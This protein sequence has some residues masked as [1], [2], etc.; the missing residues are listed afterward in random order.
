[1]RLKSFKRG[2]ALI[3]IAGATAASAPLSA[4]AENKTPVAYFGERA[5]DSTEALN[6][7]PADAKDVVVARIRLLTH[8]FWLGGRHCEFCTDDIFGAHLKVTEVLRGRS[9]IGQ[10]LD[11][12]LGQ[13]SDYRPFEFPS[14]PDQ[15]GREYTVVIYLAADGLRRLAAFPVSQAE[16]E[17]WNEERWSHQGFTGKP[18]KASLPTL[19]P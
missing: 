13:R 17:K 1:M 14:T 16:Y 3:A 8:L 2:M 9:E 4:A 7:L 18:G 19:P 11:V 5:S 15:N 6:N 10:E 12:L